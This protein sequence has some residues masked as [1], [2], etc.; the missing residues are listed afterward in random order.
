VGALIVAALA[1]GLDNFGAAIGLGAGTPGGLT[2]WRVALV[3]GFFEAAM[4]VVGLILGR[5]VAAPLAG[6]A[7]VV[8]GV[9]L[10]LIGAYSAVL[11]LSGGSPTSTGSAG[12]WRII[13][14]GAALSIDNLI[15]GFALGAFHVNFVAAVLVIAAVSV[16]LS[17]LGLELGSRLGAR[18]GERS[19]LV[20]G[21][22]LIGVGV[23]IA[24]GFR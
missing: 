17:L 7:P 15:V 24:V 9:A 10:G 6:A 18:M 4:P 5:A 13:A 16:A 20:G 23:A 21:L 3:F 19:E 11:A 14:V 8:G 22:A 1:L 12:N 2:R